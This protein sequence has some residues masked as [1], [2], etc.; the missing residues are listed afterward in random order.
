MENARRAAA[1]GVFGAA[2]RDAPRA[3]DK[4]SRALQNGRDRLASNIEEVLKDLEA[5]SAS[6]GEASK[7]EK[8][9]ECAKQ[10]AAKLCGA[11]AAGSISVQGPQG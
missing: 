1:A 4:A 10:E 11:P 7:L 6:D 5:A 3:V 2:G 8:D 9:L